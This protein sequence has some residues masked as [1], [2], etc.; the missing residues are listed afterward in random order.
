MT[1]AIPSS[2]WPISL[3]L[4]VCMLSQVHADCLVTIA[5]GTARGAVM[6]SLHGKD[7]CS[8]RGIRYAEPPVGELRFRVSMLGLLL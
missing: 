8:Y 3:L 2:F 1:Q 6:T 7:F 4:L 5:Q